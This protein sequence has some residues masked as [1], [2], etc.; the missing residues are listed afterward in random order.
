MNVRLS[1]DLPFGSARISGGN[2]SLL[3]P[4]VNTRVVWLCPECFQPSGAG[5]TVPD[6]LDR[7]CNHSEHLAPY[8]PVS[9][10]RPM[11]D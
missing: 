8:L 6:E 5:P 1:E 7:L 10:E 3:V 9:D 11:E 2:W 4:P